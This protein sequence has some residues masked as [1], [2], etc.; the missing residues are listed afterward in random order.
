MSLAPPRSELGKRS[1][2][3]MGSSNWPNIT[4]RLSHRVSVA[5]H[6]FRMS[7]GRYT[8]QFQAGLGMI[9]ENMRFLNLWEE[10]VVRPVIHAEV[11][12]EEVAEAHRILHDRENIG[13]V[14]LVQESAAS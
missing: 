5:T 11:P 8:T 7:E 10:G 14:V 2:A 6:I 3:R 13:K 9:D 1:E 12:F 4:M